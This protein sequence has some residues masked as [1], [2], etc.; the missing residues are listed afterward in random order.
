MEI[1]SLF[2]GRIQFELTVTLFYTFIGLSIGLAY[3]L[4]VGFAGKH[5]NESHFNSETFRVWLRIFALTLFSAFALGFLTIV[6]IGVVWPIMIERMGNVFGPLMFFAVVIFVVLKSTALDVMLFGKQRASVAQYKWAM[7]LVLFGLTLVAYFV[8]VFDSWTRQPAGTMMLD[9]RYRIYEWAELFVQPAAYLQSVEFFLQTIYSTAGVCL[10]FSA[11]QSKFRPLQ[12]G[13]IIFLKRALKWGVLALLVH[14]TLMWFLYTNN[15]LPYKIEIDRVYFLTWLSF[16]IT[17]FIWLVAA[18]LS[19]KLFNNQLKPKLAF[20]FGAPLG[21][22]IPALAWLT[23]SDFR[24]EFAVMNA[25]KAADV[26]TATPTT[27]IALGLILLLALFSLIIFGFV[28]LSG[29]AMKQGVVPVVK[30]GG[31]P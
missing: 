11:W 3:L 9:G 23:N 18:Y 29:Y 19:L 7:W 5:S 24:S 13:H 8:I 22:I 21:M 31:A 4:A 15:G 2:F 20:I 17:L 16:C 1:S 28:R 30:S 6:E 25:L 26:I 10:G 14:A 12:D 27:S